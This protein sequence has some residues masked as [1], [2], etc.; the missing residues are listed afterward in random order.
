VN[1]ALDPVFYDTEALSLE[2]WRSRLLSND[3]GL[4]GESN[5]LVHVHDHRVSQDQNKETIIFNEG[6][7][8]E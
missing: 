2:V 5:G 8:D 7:T 1:T 6:V 3:P 4:D